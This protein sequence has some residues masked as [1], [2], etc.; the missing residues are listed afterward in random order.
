MKV[1]CGQVPWSLYIYGPMRLRIIYLML[2]GGTLLSA[3]NR[4]TLSGEITD[5][6]T[7]EDLVGAT[8]YVAR[9]SLGAA[10]NSYGFY[11][12]TIPGGKQELVCS[13]IGYEEFK[14]KVGTHAEV[15]ILK[16]GETYNL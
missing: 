15:I 13:Y 8:V 12:L 7:G 5:S 1:C 14:Q 10:S 3:Q 11:S 4:F 9:T 16:P 6:E 2:L